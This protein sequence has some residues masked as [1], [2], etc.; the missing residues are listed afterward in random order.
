MITKSGFS[1]RVFEFAFNAEFAATHRAIVVGCPDIPTQNQEKKKA[2][3]VKFLLE[4]RGGAIGSLFLQHKVVRYVG[5]RSGANAHRYD[6]CSGPYFVF[7][8]DIDQFNVIRKQRGRG[9]AFYYCAPAFVERSELEAH[10]MSKN[11]L[12]RSVWVDVI[13]ALEIAD[14]KAHSILV[15]KGCTAGFRTSKEVIPLQ[16]KRISP[17]V[18]DLA[19]DRLERGFDLDEARDLYTAIAEALLDVNR[20][21]PAGIDADLD[22]SWRRIREGWRP[23]TVEDGIEEISR[24]SSKEIGLSWLM[25]TKQ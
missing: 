24:L 3:D 10:Y 18:G 4:Q 16:I 23:D 6:K 22:M 17:T 21:S 11:V 13:G 9:K 14:K 20:R 8:L 2:Y 19:V 25:V 7:D 1:E 5:G 15:S 12:A